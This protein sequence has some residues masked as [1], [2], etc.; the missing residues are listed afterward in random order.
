MI[1]GSHGRLLAM[2]LILF[3]SPESARAEGSKARMA[4][5]ARFQGTGGA[6]PGTSFALDGLMAST[7]SDRAR[8]GTPMKIYLRLRRAR[9]VG[10]RAP[11]AS[12]IGLAVW[13]PGSRAPRFLTADEGV[14]MR[15]ARY[16]AWL[17]F[18]PSRPGLWRIAAAVRM[19]SEWIAGDRAGEISFRCERAGQTWP[20]APQDAWVLIYRRGRNWPRGRS[21]LDLDLTEHRSWLQGLHRQGRLVAAGPFVDD[22]G[23]LLVL[24]A[25]SREEALSL[26]GEDPA[27]RQ[28]IFRVEAHPWY[29]IDWKR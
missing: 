23:E 7:W 26:I 16:R 9:G 28:K 21:L 4:S 25:S 14:V 12:A 6:I 20:M 3:L 27:I 22:G 10:T 1:R 19:G 17:D 5:V 11:R 15:Q 29:A 13:A 2:V 18:A 8:A 24:R